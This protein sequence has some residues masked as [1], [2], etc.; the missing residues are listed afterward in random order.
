MSFDYTFSYLKELFMNHGYYFH[1]YVEKMN[2][3]DSGVVNYYNVINIEVYDKDKNCI[4]Y[5]QEVYDCLKI[6]E[7]KM[8]KKCLDILIGDY[9]ILS[10]SYSNINNILTEEI[11]NLSIT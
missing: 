7:E 2:N 9:D 4:F 3:I 1:Y 6:A 11:N 8:C 10:E 5:T